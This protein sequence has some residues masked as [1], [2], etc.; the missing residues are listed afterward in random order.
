MSGSGFKERHLAEPPVQGRPGDAEAGSRT[1]FGSGRLGGSGAER[2]TS[3]AGRTEDRQAEGEL[4]GQLVDGPSGPL[5][6]GPRPHLT[7]DGPRG[8]RGSEPGAGV[9]GPEAGE[10]GGARGSVRLQALEHGRLCGRRQAGRGNPEEKGAE[11]LQGLGSYSG[12]AGRCRCPKKTRKR[13]SCGCRRHAAPRAEQP[14]GRRPHPEEA[15][16]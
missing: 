5:A 1:L 2:S 8:R 15:W 12:S 6:G 3:S 13:L 4:P 11:W 16:A 10:A 9:G 7:R 14:L